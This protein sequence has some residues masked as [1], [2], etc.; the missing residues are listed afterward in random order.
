MSI[1]RD[2]HFTPTQK[3]EYDSLRARGRSMYDDLRW[4]ENATHA[5]AFRD[6]RY[7]Y[8][9]KDNAGLITAGLIAG[10]RA[11]LERVRP[12]ESPEW[13]DARVADY[14]SLL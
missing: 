5:D 3:R 11:D 8:G 13:I 6:A 4:N 1:D 14:A 10:Y 2:H 9:L 7:S 12:N